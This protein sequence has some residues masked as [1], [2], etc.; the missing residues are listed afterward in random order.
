[1]C[2]KLSI[3]HPSM[4]NSGY[5]KWNVCKAF[6][7]FDCSHI[8]LFCSLVILPR[9]DLVPFLVCSCR[10][11]QVEVPVYGGK[12]FSCLESPIAGKQNLHVVDM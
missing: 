1:M 4:K 5:E 9:D 10:K 8:P 12:I 3:L 11:T 2:D 6:V 7:L